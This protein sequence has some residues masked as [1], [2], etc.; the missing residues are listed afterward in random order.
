MGVAASLIARLLQKHRWIAYV[1][2]AII[3]YVSVDVIYRGA[4][5]AWPLINGA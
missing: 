2:L 1:G 4:L 3:L 5:E